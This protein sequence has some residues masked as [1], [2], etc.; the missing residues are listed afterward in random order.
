MARQ[1]IKKGRHAVRFFDRFW[2]LYR[3]QSHRVVVKITGP[4]LRYKLNTVD[5]YDWN[6]LEGIAF[7]AYQ[8]HGRTV[9]TGWRYNTNLGVVEFCHYYHNILNKDEYQPVGRV[10]GYIQPGKVLRVPIIKGAVEVII[11]R[12]IKGDVVTTTISDILPGNEIRDKAAFTPLSKFCTRI[13]AWFGGNRPAEDELTL[14]KI[15]SSPL[16]SSNNFK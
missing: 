7:D 8:P 16:P 10:P 6:K 14:Y 5:Q 15:H 1:K 9:M 13:N 12:E 3:V 11:T 4:G 2:H